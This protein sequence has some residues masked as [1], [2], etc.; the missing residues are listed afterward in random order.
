[1]FDEC[2]LSGRELAFARRFIISRNATKA[3][4]E[5]GYAKT[6]AHVAGHR[7]LQRPHVRDE[8]ERLEAKALRDAAQITTLIRNA[9]EAATSAIG[10]GPAEASRERLEVDAD[11][12]ASTTR[13]HILA[14]LIESLEVSLG[15]RKRLVSR[16]RTA[17]GKAGE[18]D[19]IEAFNVEIFDPNPH[20]ANATAAILLKELANH[21]TPSA[22]SPSENP[23]LHPDLAEALR[24]F[25]ESRPTDPV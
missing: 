12:V 3:A 5:A 24:T 13:I 2:V 7:L 23:D 22:A 19:R 21:P 6:S 25:W 18:P 4:A 10:V 16:L 14:A 11:T 1:M 8:I 17:R 20:A 15:R 9:N